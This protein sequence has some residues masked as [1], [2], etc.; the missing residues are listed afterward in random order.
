[1]KYISYM[2]I[3]VIIRDVQA[4]GGH[5]GIRKMLLYYSYIENSALTEEIVIL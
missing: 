5:L 1:M 2:T 3:R 4:Y